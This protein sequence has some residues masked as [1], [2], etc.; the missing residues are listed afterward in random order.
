VVIDDSILNCL[1]GFG[2][3]IR[4]YNNKRL[5]FKNDNRLDAKFVY[6]HYATSLLRHY[7]QQTP[8]IE[9]KIEALVDG[10]AW[11]NTGPWYDLSTLKHM[12]EYWGDVAIRVFK[13]TEIRSD[14]VA[15]MGGISLKDDNEEKDSRLAAGAVFK[16]LIGDDFP[17]VVEDE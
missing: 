10:R 16:E 6:W 11:G 12:A 14:E 1:A 9:Q 5:V 2:K 3:K 15:R 4:D 17:E 13:D 7:K 8:G